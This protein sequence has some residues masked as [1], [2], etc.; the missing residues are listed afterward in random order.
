MLGQHGEIILNNIHAC[1]PDLAK[2]W[3]VAVL[4]EIL[5]EEGCQLM[6]YLQHD[7]NQTMSKQSLIKD[8]SICTAYTLP[9]P[10]MSSD[11]GI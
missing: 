9:T 8:E 5:T 7:E 2:Q 1:Q 6:K 10:I 3:A 11:S 4:R